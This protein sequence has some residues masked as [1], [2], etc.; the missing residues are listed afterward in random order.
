M[1]FFLG[2]LFSTW[3]GRKI[4]WAISRG[5][6]YSTNVAVCFVVCVIWGLGTAYALRVF[7]LATN[8][9]LLLK[10]FGYGGGA[11]V[12]IPNYGLLNEST[13]PETEMPRHVLIKGVPFL[14]FIVA[15]VVFAFFISVG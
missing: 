10:I 12:S 4:G 1:A 2:V 7:M 11:Y 8:P 5:L 14:V 3:I 13:I 15:S 9:G 6:L